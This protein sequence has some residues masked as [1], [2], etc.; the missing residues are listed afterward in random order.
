MT[1]VRKLKSHFIAEIEIVRETINITAFIA[2][3]LIMF[4]E[5][6]NFA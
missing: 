4:T 6:G 2:S 5:G 1:T 3:I